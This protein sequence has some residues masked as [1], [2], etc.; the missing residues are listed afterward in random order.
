MSK[1]SNLKRTVKGLFCAFVIHQEII[2]RL[3][4]E[5]TS[6]RFKISANACMRVTS[7]GLF[8]VAALLSNN[9]PTLLSFASDALLMRERSAT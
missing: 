4:E 7:V 2:H 8:A 9:I 6:G 5:D 3:A 1:Y